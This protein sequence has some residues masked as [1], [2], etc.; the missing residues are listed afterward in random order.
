MR[1][2]LERTVV[3]RANDYPCWKKRSPTLVIST[4]NWSIL[5]KFAK[6]KSSKIGC[7]LLIVSWQSFPQKFPVKSADFSKNLPLKILRNLTFFAKIPRNRLIFLPILTFPPCEIGRFSP[8]FCLF[9]PRNQPIF[10]EFAPVNPAKFC[11]FFRKISETLFKTWYMAFSLC[12][13]SEPA[14]NQNQQ[15]VSR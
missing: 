15:L 2:F 3:E 1:S 5:T 10:H 6:K 11:F 8:E 12:T 7:F 4:Q 9:L 13:S 14:I